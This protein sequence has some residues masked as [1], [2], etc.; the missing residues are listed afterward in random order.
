MAGAHVSHRASLLHVRVRQSGERKLQTLKLRTWWENREHAE[1]AS[2]RKLPPDLEHLH[3]VNVG[4]AC[5]LA[6]HEPLRSAFLHEVR[7]LDGFPSKLRK[8]DRKNLQCLQDRRNALLVRKAF[9]LPRL[10]EF[11]LCIW[12]TVPQAKYQTRAPLKVLCLKSPLP[13][14]VQSLP[15]TLEEL[16]LNTETNMDTEAQDGP[17]ARVTRL[18]LDRCAN[19]SVLSFCPNVRVLKLSHTL[20][21]PLL[22]PFLKRAIFCSVHA[23]SKA[24]VF[25]LASN[26]RHLA[27]FY[28]A[29]TTD[30]VRTACALPLQS[31]EA[32][33]ISQ[34]GQHASTMRRSQS[35]HHQ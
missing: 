8:L 29:L 34:R 30:D 24:R 6:E 1:V 9:D 5:S 35:L 2:I 22:P 4:L 18:E 20:M 14:E 10:E 11:R 27:L 28:C 33:R 17:L 16:N 15:T 31:L 3:L 7:G 25:A 12:V 21:P 19:L 32:T 26:L 13:G 23:A